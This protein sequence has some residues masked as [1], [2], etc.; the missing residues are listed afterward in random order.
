MKILQG[1]VSLFLLKILSQ[2]TLDDEG[3]GSE[4]YFDAKKIWFIEESIS[5]FEKMR[6]NLI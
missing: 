1:K 3:Q 4:S 5:L 2:N 6:S